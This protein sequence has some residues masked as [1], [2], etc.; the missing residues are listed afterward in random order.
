MIEKEIAELRRRLKTD[1]NNIRAIH[2][3]YVNEK[4]ELVSSF[5]QSLALMPEDEAEKLLALLKKSLSGQVGRNL[6]DITFTT[7]QVVDSDEHRL[8]MALRDTGP[9]GG[10]QLQA[11]YQRVAG[12]LALEG[13]YLILLANDIYDVPYRSR[14]GQRLEDAASEVFSYV[15]CGIFP[16]KTTKPAL[17]YSLT[18]NEFHSLR[19]DSVITPPELGF[20]FPAFDDRCA[21]I[22]NALYYTRN[23]AENHAGLVDAVFHAEIP[24]PAAEQKETFEAILED[25][26][27]E[28]CSYEVVQSVQGQL[29]DM[30]LEHKANK[31]EA[32]L[33]VSKDTV[34]QVLEACGVAQERIGAFDE[35]FDETFGENADLSP[36]NLVDTKQLEMRTPEVSIRVKPECGNLVETRV[37]DGAKYIVI[38][39]HEGV[40]V[41]GVSVQFAQEPEAAEAN[42]NA[43]HRVPEPAGVL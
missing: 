36:R 10:E 8:L 13:S 34:K 14:D 40:E 18:G 25:T 23:S 41:N 1:K 19:T 35:R 28:D 26:L 2:G 9:E 37:I 42:E 27:A 12:A 17:S 24:M 30:I 16:V 31:E 6:I 33:V 4:R 3:C 5:T 15:L 22:Y 20:L 29:C 43:P 32:P 7:Q 39:V 11:F 21:N 38:R